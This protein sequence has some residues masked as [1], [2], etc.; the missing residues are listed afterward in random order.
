MTVYMEGVDGKLLVRTADSLT[1]KAWWRRTRRLADP[2]RKEAP[3]VS[4][5]GLS[6]VRVRVRYPMPSNDQYT[7]GE[8]IVKRAK[9]SIHNPLP[10]ACASHLT[11]H[12]LLLP[13]S[14]KPNTGEDLGRRCGHQGA[15]SP[16]LGSRT[17]GRRD[18]GNLNRLA[19]RLGTQP[20]CLRKIGRRKF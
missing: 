12:F 13:F 4:P 9:G 17:T 6:R 15:R 2:A 7:G 3:G 11:G 19:S 16:D 14:F 1:A 10:V 20:K 8:L 18:P 5:R